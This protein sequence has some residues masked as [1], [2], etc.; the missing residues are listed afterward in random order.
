MMSWLLTNRYL[1]NTSTQ[2]SERIW[3]QVFELQKFI[4]LSFHQAV[5]RAEFWLPWHPRSYSQESVMFR[6]KWDF[7]DVIKVT[8][9]LTLKC[10]PGGP[11]YPYKPWKAEMYF[12]WQQRDNQRFK[13][14]DVLDM[15]LLAWSWILPITWIVGPPEPSPANTLIW[16]WE[17]L[18]RG[19]SRVMRA[20]TYGPW[21]VRQCVVVVFKFVDICWSISRN[22]M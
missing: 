15:L 8:D 13:A 10:Y 21:T 9:Q 18:S 11:V 3:P 7:E 1:L 4:W 16:P 6:G 20:G 17:A 5:W 14:W 22:L 19:L 12:G 2:K